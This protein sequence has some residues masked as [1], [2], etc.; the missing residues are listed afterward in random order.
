MSQAAA[1]RKKSLSKIIRFTT[2]VPTI[3]IGERQRDL[4]AEFRAE[5]KLAELFP[6]VS[7]ITDSDGAK[8]IPISEVL[9]FEQ[10]LN[11]VHEEAYA[12]G[13]Q[14]GFVEGLEKGRDEARKVLAQFDYAIRDAIQQRESMLEESRE[15][16][17]DLVLKISRKVTFDAIEFDRESIVTMISRIIDNL[18]DRS[19]LTI[20]VHPDHLPIL[21]QNIDRFLQNSTAIKE[22]R[23]EPDP[24]VRYGGCFIETPTGDI[25]ARLESQFEVISD[26]VLGVEQ[27]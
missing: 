25:D 4:N 7:F 3:F 24:R 6:Q 21:E 1:A 5:R 9:I 2:E 17:L 27:P 11:R 8:L 13:Q 16:I 10:A 12:A 23:F 26:V 15:R 22:L 14:K 18:V 20:K 19:R